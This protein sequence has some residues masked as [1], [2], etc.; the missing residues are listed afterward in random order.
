MR[1]YLRAR[2]L[3]ATGMDWTDVLAVEDENRRARRAA[4]LLAND[5]YGSTAARVRAIVEQGGRMPGDVLQLPALSTPVDNAGNVAELV[6]CCRRWRSPLPL[7]VVRM[8][9]HIID[10]ITAPQRSR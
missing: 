7:H 8:E 10:R 4:E 3:K 6:M 2:E 5:A 1:H 9:H